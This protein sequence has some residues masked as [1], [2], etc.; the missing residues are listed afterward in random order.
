VLAQEIAAIGLVLRDLGRGGGI[1]VEVG[2]AEDVP[3][4]GRKHDF[5]RE[6]ELRLELDRRPDLGRQL[7][8]QE[9][10]EGMLHRR[11]S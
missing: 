8:D 11:G 2:V 3:L 4:A 5:A 6:F 10:G 7:F 1:D 9:R